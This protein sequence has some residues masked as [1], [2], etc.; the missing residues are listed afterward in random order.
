MVEYPQQLSRG[1]VLVKWWLLV[2]PHLLIVAAFTGTTWTWQSQ[3]GDWGAAYER[4][5]GLSL[6]GLLVLIAALALL[7]TSRYPRPLFE[8]ILGINRWI[9]RVLAYAALMRDEYP[10]FRLDQGAREPVPPEAGSFPGS[11]PT[12]GQ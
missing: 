11:G 1:L 2:I 6:L 8:L 9:Y 5:T 3:A 4:G 10:P 7:F 12:A